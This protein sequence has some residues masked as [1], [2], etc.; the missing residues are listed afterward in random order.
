MSVQEVNILIKGLYSGEIS[1]LE[2]KPNGLGEWNFDDMQSQ[3]RIRY[4][5]KWQEGLW[6]GVGD[7][8]ETF[9]TSG[10]KITVEL[11]NGL[12]S[13]GK[14][15]FGDSSSDAHITINKNTDEGKML[16]IHIY[17][18][19]KQNETKNSLK[20]LEEA[21]FSKK[22]YFHN[23]IIRN[24]F[25]KLTQIHIIGN[26]LRKGGYQII[27]SWTID[28]NQYRLG[29]ILKN[30]IEDEKKRL[31]SDLKTEIRKSIWVCDES[32]R[33][34]ILGF[35][36]K[37]A[38]ADVKLEEFLEIILRESDDKI[39][40]KSLKLIANCL[41]EIIELLHES[42]LKN[43]VY[44]D[45]HANTSNEI[46]SEIESFIQND[47]FKFLQ[48]LND[49][50]IPKCKLNLY[51]ILLFDPNILKML[52]D[53]RHI[54]SD[55]FLSISFDF[56]MTDEKSKTDNSDDSVSIILSL[57]SHS[58]YDYFTCEQNLRKLMKLESSMYFTYG[59][60]DFI[61]RVENIKEA[62][63][64]YK[65][66]FPHLLSILDEEK[67]QNFRESETQ[68]SIDVFQFIKKEYI[69][70]LENEFLLESSGTIVNFNEKH[71]ILIVNIIN[72]LMKG[73]CEAIGLDSCVLIEALKS[74]RSMSYGFLIELI[75]FKIN[76][77][78]LIKKFETL[79]EVLKSQIKEQMNFFMCLY[80]N[81][82]EV[83]FYMTEY[84]ERFYLKQ[85]F[86]IMEGWQKEFSDF[87]LIKTS[88][89]EIIVRIL[90]IYEFS[91]E[92]S[93]LEKSFLN[94]DFVFDIMDLISKQITFVRNIESLPLYHNK[95]EMSKEMISQ[96]TEK[97]ELKHVSYEILAD[98]LRIIELIN[99]KVKKVD[100][101]K[102]IKISEKFYD[103]LAALIN[104]FPE[105]LNVDDSNHDELEAYTDG[106]LKLFQDLLEI[107]EIDSLMEKVGC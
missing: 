71:D 81:S 102:F 13:N 19:M 4:R 68:V 106:K 72:E 85:M 42:E 43:H 6:H 69:K 104:D 55:F 28:E 29:K 92:V 52:T 41:K 8:Y 75:K 78:D 45:T 39:C 2:L 25:Q 11:P 40:T 63:N 84:K 32:S 9:Q 105:Q 24:S 51:N 34:F 16:E 12:F 38:K 99:Y 46:K 89:N 14:L 96:H 59:W 65:T 21:T 91:M 44:I 79:N 27:G 56:E 31:I 73:F 76:K 5:G 101:A 23:E 53:I 107:E 22:F 57:I 60:N 54:I 88:F 26:Y 74:N 94:R 66:Y 95:T 58:W 33:Y 62:C 50:D 1:G 100:F 61:E 80:T 77:E 97:S 83:H 82:I 47:Y 10:K 37:I 49:V 98:A 36:V 3:F 86:S 103:I 15:I 48:S 90:T 70:L 87:K 64:S 20:F 18:Y 93:L 17:G 30:E 35:Y 7:F 67:Y